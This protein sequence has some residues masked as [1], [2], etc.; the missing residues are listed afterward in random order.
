VSPVPD[1]A[2]ASPFAYA[3]DSPLGAVDLIGHRPTAPQGTMPASPPR[4]APAPKPATTSGSSCTSWCSPPSPLQRQD[5]PIAEIT[6]SLHLGQ[7]SYGVLHINGNDIPSGIDRDAFA[8][9][10]T[11]YWRSRAASLAGGG[12]DG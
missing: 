7:G 8:A 2:D 4:P 3:G 9:W 5:G 11:S 10:K 6:Q 1:S 12:G